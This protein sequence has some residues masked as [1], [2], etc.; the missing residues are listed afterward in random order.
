MATSPQSLVDNMFRFRNNIFLLWHCDRT[1]YSL[2]KCILLV[3][4]IHNDVV[5]SY[6]IKTI[7]NHHSHHIKNSCL[8]LLCGLTLWYWCLSS[9]A[10]VQFQMHLLVE[11]LVRCQPPRDMWLDVL[12]QFGMNY[13]E[14][15]TLVGILHATP[16]N[17]VV[18][19]T[20]RHSRSLELSRFCRVLLWLT[21]LN[22]WCCIIF[23]PN[24]CIY[25]WCSWYI[26]KGKLAKHDL[27]QKVQI[28]IEDIWETMVCF[29]LMKINNISTVCRPDAK[30]IMIV[31][32]GFY[33]QSAIN[34]FCK[35]L[36]YTTSYNWF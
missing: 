25:L 8:G 3:L 22:N 15:R 35:F 7:Y 12:L 27:R 30:N 5:C 16:S 4:E 32:T 9:Y 6:N 11:S 34:R 36:L 28:S 14:V 20:I 1:I 17:Y 10:N 21:T 24:L 29:T 18:A 19:R 2:W 26:A 33:T 23:F 31:W 13:T